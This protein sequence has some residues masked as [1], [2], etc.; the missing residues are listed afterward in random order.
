MEPKRES[1]PGSGQGMGTLIVFAT[2]DELRLWGPLAV[3]EMLKRARR[4]QVT[5]V[6][7]LV[8]FVGHQTALSRGDG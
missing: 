7:Q 8:E 5:G 3:R 2:L 4:P 1:P 6:A